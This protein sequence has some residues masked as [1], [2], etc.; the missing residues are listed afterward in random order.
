MKGIHKFCIVIPIYKRFPSTN[1]IFSLQRVIDLYERRYDIF[2]VG[3]NELNHER[4]QIGQRKIPFISFPLRYFKSVFSYN[5]LLLSPSFYRPFY[6][7]ER[8]LIHQLDAFIFRDMLDEVCSW[9][10]DYIGAPWLNDA[11]KIMMDK[12]FNTTFFRKFFLPVG[13]GGFSLRNPKKSL[14]IAILFLPFKLLWRK[15]WNEDIF[16]STLCYR[17]IPGYKVANKEKAVLFSVEDS[18][19]KALKMLH[20][21]LPFG[22]HAWEKNNPEFWRPHFEKLGFR[23]SV[24]SK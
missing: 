14:W 24:N 10:Y 1:E 15:K 6:A 9:G 5:S 7:Y 4:Y 20:G 22:C 18:P 21:Q 13:N 11:W 19:E 16:W 2:L 23:M 12:R 8:I 17:F 3:P